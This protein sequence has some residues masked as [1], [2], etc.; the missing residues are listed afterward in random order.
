MKNLFAALENAEGEVELNTDVVPEVEMD[1]EVAAADTGEAAAEIEELTEVVEDA[2][3]EVETLGEITDNLEQKVEEGEGVSPETVEIAEIA[4]EAIYKKL[5]IKSSVKPMP[6]IENFKSKNSAQASLRVAVEGMGETIKNV[7][8]KIV[9]V[10]KGIWQKIVDFFSKFFANAEKVKKAA[11]AI[12]DQAAKAKGTK[13]EDKLKLGGVAKAFGDEKGAFKMDEVLSNHDGVS[14]NISGSLDGLRAASD[15]L[16][17]FIK[18][19]TGGLPEGFSSKLKSVGEKLATGVTSDTSTETEGQDSLVVNKMGPFV[20]GQ[21]VT[22]KYGAGRFGVSFGGSSKAASEELPALDAAGAGKVADTVIKLMDTTLEIKKNQ[23]KIE[24]VQKAGI[25][26]AESVIS[27]ADKIADTAENNSETKAGI[28]KARSA[29][30]EVSNASGRLTSLLPAL[31]VRAGKF[32]LNYA[33]AS[34]KNL[35][36]KKAA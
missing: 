13:K 36:E 24:A 34:L 25:K 32:A 30:V 20:G 35:E 28:A 27:L 3:N 11:Q 14:K 2:V 26:V 15:S 5:G 17:G 18:N 16:E 6:A 7:W 29:L 1:A 33:S 23:S 8:K 19:P 21:Y 12:K 22:V 9:A 10:L 4:V 31:N